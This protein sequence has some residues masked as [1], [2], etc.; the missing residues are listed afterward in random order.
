M[1]IFSHEVRTIAKTRLTENLG[2][3]KLEHMSVISAAL[4]IAMGLP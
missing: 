3:L 4:K 1:E 2:Q